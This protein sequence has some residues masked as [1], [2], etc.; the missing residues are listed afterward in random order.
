MGVFIMAN[1][2]FWKYDFRT[3]GEA[4]INNGLSWLIKVLRKGCFHNGPVMKTP[5]TTFVV[6]HVYMYH[7]Q[8]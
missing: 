5:I 6:F 7:Q 1:Y 2:K 3:P 8:Y 4:Y